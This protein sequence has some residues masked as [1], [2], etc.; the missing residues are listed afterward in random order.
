MAISSI[1]RI[2]AALM[3]AGALASTA[4]QPLETARKAPSANVGS[5]ALCRAIPRFVAQQGFT[6]QALLSTSERWTMGLV[7]VEGQ[8]KE[9]TWQ[10]A[11]WK[12]GGWLAGIHLDE[13]GNV[14]TVPAPR[15]SVLGNNPKAQ[16]TVFKVD[17]LTAQMTQLA[18]L[19]AAAPP[20]EQN[21]YGAL[22]LAYDCE[23]R[24]LYVTSIAGSTRNKEVGRIFALDPNNGSIRSV[25]DEVDAFGLA[26]FK[27][28]KEKR[29]Y[30]GKAREAQI[31]SVV[32]DAS[33]KFAGK[34]RF[35]L[36][37]EGMG[38]RGDD[39]ARRINFSPENEML[40]WGVEFSF[41]LVAPTEKQETLY[42]FRFLPAKDQWERVRESAFER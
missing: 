24:L 1:T 18:A 27:T 40:V 31:W 20:N 14:Y 16:N 7:L 32:V 42:R 23:T 6:S 25:L 10:H 28:G 13:R 33:G 26:L 37:L 4:A 17:S 3:A 15:I 2:A 5:V 12:S 29:L 9:K 11:S 35:E 38:P 34:P 22:G 41:N 21:P 30:F 36:S 39:R 8:N 19:P